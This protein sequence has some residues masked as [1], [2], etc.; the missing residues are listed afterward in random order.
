M[1][2]YYMTSDEVT[3]WVIAEDWTEAYTKLYEQD[4]S[5]DITATR[6]YSSPSDTVVL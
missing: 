2:V 6:R 4:P 1:N 3:Y 5:A